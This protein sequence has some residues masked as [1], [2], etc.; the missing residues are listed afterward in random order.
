[1]A[2]NKEKATYTQNQLEQLSGS[3]KHSDSTVSSK[4]ADVV[5]ADDGDGIS[6]KRPQ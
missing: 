4:R 1:M 6:T 3:Y 2:K 5:H